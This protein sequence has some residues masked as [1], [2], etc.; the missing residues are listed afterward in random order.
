[1]AGVKG[2]RWIAGIISGLTGSMML[3]VPHQF[4]N[5]SYVLF[6]SHL[7]WWGVAFLLSGLGLLASG[8]PS[9]PF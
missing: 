5:P 4:S 7:E 3:I 9:L 6:A 1:M 8:L 2:L